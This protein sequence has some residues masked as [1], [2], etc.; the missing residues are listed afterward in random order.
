MFENLCI[1]K[2]NLT[3][4]IYPVH[5][6]ALKTQWK[7]KIWKASRTPKKKHSL[8]VV[9]EKKQISTWKYNLDKFTYKIRD[10]DTKTFA[11]YSKSIQLFL[12]LE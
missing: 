7:R 9:S 3:N 12:E 2:E 10:I 5:E 4:T 6:T 8:E 1:P 11:L